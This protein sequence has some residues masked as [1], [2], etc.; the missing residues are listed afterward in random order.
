MKHYLEPFGY[1]PI[2]STVSLL[3]YIIKSTKFYLCVD[4]FSIKFWSEED[5]D[6]LCNVIGANFRY[7]IDHEG[8]NYCDL[9]QDWNYKWGYI[10]IL[11]PKSIPAALKKLNYQPKIFPQYLPHKHM[12]IIYGN[13]ATQ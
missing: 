6:H 12:L 1:R 11:M 8:K 10:D 4:N 9:Q 5:A 7:T 3:H 13:K 2:K